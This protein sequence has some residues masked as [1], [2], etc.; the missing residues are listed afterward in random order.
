VSVSGMQ[1]EG[2]AEVHV[3]GLAGVL[4]L[5]TFLDIRQPLVHVT[6]EHPFL[7]GRCQGG[8]YVKMRTHSDARTMYLWRGNRLPRWR[9]CAGG[10]W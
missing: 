8:G 7:P 4:C 1:Q 5:L 9:V 10:A 3:T 2:V 6:E